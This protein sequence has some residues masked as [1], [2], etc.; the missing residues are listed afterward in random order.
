VAPL[1]KRARLLEIRLGTP[2]S[3]LP[4]AL[5]TQDQFNRRVRALALELRAL[6]RDFAGQIAEPSALYRVLDTTLVPAI[7][8]VRTSGNGLFFCAQASFGRSASKT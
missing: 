5:C 4:E 2:A 1:Q 6:Q 8:R 7:V 3:L